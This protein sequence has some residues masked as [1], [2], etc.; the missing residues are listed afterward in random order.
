MRITSRILAFLVV[1]GTSAGLACAGANSE[2]EIDHGLLLVANK[3]DRT[4][5]IIDPASGRQLAAVPVGGTTGHEVAVSPDGRTAWVPIYG[6]S[7]VGQPGTDGRAISII[8]LKAWT[9]LAEIDLGA[10]SRPHHAV[11]GPNDG[12]LYVTSELTNSIQV[13]DPATRKVIASIPTGAPESHMLA[14]SSNGERA[15]TSNVGAG[16]ISVIDLRARRVLAVIPIAKT[17][18]RIAISGDNR[19]VFTADQT[20]PRIAVIDTLSNAVRQWIPLSDLGFGMAV[21]RD[22]SRLLVTHPA[23]STVSIAD[24]HSMKVVRTI[25]V[26][27]SPQEIL[28]R[29]DNRVAYV[30]CDE[31]KKVAVIDLSTEKLQKLIA[32]G[33]GADGLAWAT[34]RLP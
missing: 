5:S 28:I 34:I 23:S 20:K 27:A 33:S 31:S 2:Q 21:S 4:L 32:A 19:W 29:P 6:D 11:F 24:L 30:S 1:I 16:S 12:R 22:G 15:Y 10:P 8:D 26:P 14:I 25:H 13:I 7:G 18:Q 9:K 3:G 17:V